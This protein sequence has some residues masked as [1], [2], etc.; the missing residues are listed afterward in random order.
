MARRL[1]GMAAQKPK[2]KKVGTI[3]H[4]YP[5]VHAASVGLE[6]D[7]K[8][9]D[10]IHIKGHGD[11]L[12]GKV[13]S[14]QLDHVPI[15]EGHAGQHIGVQVRKKVHK[16]A[17]VFKVLPAPTPKKAAKKAPRKAAK[18]ARKPKKAAKKAPKRAT[19]AGK[20][21]KR[22]KRAAKAKPKK[23]A[24]RTAGKARRTAKR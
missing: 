21:P 3:E 4:Y 6:G 12:T 9:G 18:A 24:K 14:M 5:K 22:A 13:G 1:P 23:A 20:A 19:K 7:L 8:L 15:Q 2:E 10:T 17:D 16:K 11:D